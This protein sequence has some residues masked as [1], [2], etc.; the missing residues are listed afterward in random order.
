[1]RMRR[2]AILL[3][4]SAA[5]M[6]S[7]AAEP[8]VDGVASQDEWRQGASH[9]GLVT[10][11]GAVFPSM[12]RV[13]TLRGGGR[14]YV[15][16]ESAVPER[17]IL[18]RVMKDAPG[19]LAGI[20]DAVLIRL[21]DGRVVSVNAFCAV[22]A[23]GG[24]IPRGIAAA[25]TVTNGWWTLEASLPVSEI[26]D[27]GKVDVGRHF[28]L[29]EAGRERDA[30]VAK[31]GGVFPPV[32]RPFAAFEDVSGGSDS[33]VLSG[34][35]VN[36]ADE[37]AR[38]HLSV[39]ARPS[40]SQPA[41]LER[42][43][44]LKAGDV[45]PFELKGAILGDEEV[46]V[47]ADG[48]SWRLRPNNASDPFAKDLAAADAVSVKF[49][50]YPSY[51]K[52]HLRV[53]ASLVPDWRRDVKGVLFTLLD[54]ATNAV[55]KRV[56]GVNTN[57]LAE[58]IF[59]I[60]DLRPMTVRSGNPQYLMR[61]ALDGV[62]GK[63]YEKRLYRHAMEWEGNKYGLSD[64]VV[65]PF[66]AISQS[67]DGT[68]VGTIL[69]KHC[70]NSLGLFEQVLCPA[71]EGSRE[72]V[73]PIL[74]KGGMKLVATI[75]GRDVELKGRLFIEKSDN[76]VKR[77]WTSE[78]DMAG[79]KGGVEALFEYDWQL[80]WRLRVE[81]GR[82]DA[83]R[84]VVPVRAEEGRLMHAVVDTQGRNYAGV[85]PPGSGRVWDSR[86]AKGRQSI[87]GSYLPYVWVGGPLRGMSV[88]GDNDRGWEQ[89]A[90]W[91]VAPSVPAQEVVR[92]RDGTVCLVLNLGQKPFVVTESRTIRIGFMATPVK[93]MKD[94]WRSW[95]AGLFY[96]SGVCWG[97]GP[98]DADVQ[99][100]DGTDEFWRKIAEARDTG[101]WDAKYLEDAVSRC[102][103]PGKPGDVEYEKKK[104]SIRH[105]FKAGL[106][107]AARC[108]RGRAMV[109]YTNAR[110]VDY[111]IPSGATYCDEWNI[112]TF[113]DLDRDFTRFSKR[114]YFLDPNKA[115]RDY[116]GW[117]YR[118]MIT[119][120]AGDRLYW[121]VVQPKANFDTVGTDAYVVPGG[122]VQPSL[123]M[124]N[125]REL[126]KRCATIQAELGVDATGNW[127]HMTNT[128]IAP[129][130]AF[131]GVHFDMED[132]V[133]PQAFQKKYPLGYMQAC[134][135]GRQF[136]AVVR[137][138]GYFAAAGK[139]R[140][141]W[142]QR[143][144]AGVMLTHE[145]SW[146]WNSHVWQKVHKGLVSWGYR[147]PRV[148]VWNYWNRDVPYPLAVD[149]I[150]D[151]ASIVMRK[152]DGTVR[153]VVSDYG[154]KGGSVRLV[155]DAGLLG[156]GGDFFAFDAESGAPLQVSR[157]AVSLS[158]KPF[159]FAV[160]GIGKD[161]K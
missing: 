18:R 138:M 69:R 87:L 2:R 7:L 154:G 68:V 13:R 36:P 38:F 27:L 45:V 43:L 51:N 30:Y 91:P 93:P 149:G 6:A 78:I 151:A 67:G 1:M 17:G 99:P 95:D 152:D 8:V 28:A 134:V 62:P 44:A 89:S 29:A 83:L 59:D 142:Y 153:I 155:P 145:L 157:G 108:R 57:G 84:L 16:V 125:M 75:D 132:D 63:P 23:K 113:L 42:D 77:R 5:A 54:A 82:F 11:D 122:R 103:Y 24:E 90:G 115:F 147:S 140:A 50:Y 109:W 3:P 48:R 47:V 131:A 101:K 25:S 159:D 124:F 64:I 12:V 136:G 72:P 15:A 158:I 116:A 161:A 129:N 133:S 86:S 52:F 120:R 139:E 148:R 102:P 10:S 53:D 32:N 37:T 144:G 31:K 14:A 97:A 111:G 9:I 127:I 94:N 135:I 121:D 58:E 110:G 85:V 98:M 104:A 19:G 114:A 123:G 146:R 46:S 65:Q 49:A 39:R 61:V 105:H 76:P 22:A 80:E 106:V 128:A 117:W 156:L 141:E 118:K 88:Y 35:V 81:R 92:E 107:D 119:T 143:T 79:V 137:V 33:Y 21:A 126:I 60:P 4:L 70:L 100:F 40:A 130:S 56:V 26:G 34:R 96:G 112:N 150:G 41:G 20:D 73:R 71:A 74:A 66:T 160:V 55:A